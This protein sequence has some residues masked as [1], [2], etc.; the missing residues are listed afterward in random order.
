MLDSSV[1]TVAS[2]AGVTSFFSFFAIRQ[3]KSLPVRF[4]LAV[5]LVGFY[6]AL[7]VLVY[8]YRTATIPSALL[9]CI[10][11]WLASFKLLM[12]VFARGPLA[13][14]A[15]N[16]NILRF[17]AVLCS[18]INL[19]PSLGTPKRFQQKVESSSKFLGQCALKVAILLVTVQIVDKKEWLHIL[20]YNFFCYLNLYLFI[21][22]VM[23]LFAAIVSWTLGIE[24]LPDFNR[25]FLSQSLAEFWARRWNLTVS[26]ALRGAVYEPMLEWLIGKSGQGLESLPAKQLALDL[27]RQVGQPPMTREHLG[28]IHDMKQDNRFTRASKNRT[29]LTIKILPVLATFFV[30]G[31]M[32]EL[33]VWYLTHTVTGEMTAFFTLHGV[34]T[35]VEQRIHTAFPFTAKLP[36]LLAIVIT[37]TFCF[38]SADWLFLPPL[39]R[40]GVDKRVIVEMKRGLFLDSKVLA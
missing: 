36:R 38:L 6:L 12:L 14:P 29:T 33:A 31:I 7:P 15:V 30:S 37:L 10:F 34:A 40:A 17:S 20:V 23:D 11:S 26:G 18:P 1:V 9:G 25:P 4:L 8:D 32:H 24:L 27:T 21:S 28:P 39:Y 22:L 35:I 2:A 5:P 19:K 3:Q 16:N 13:D